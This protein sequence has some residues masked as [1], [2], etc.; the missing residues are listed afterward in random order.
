MV[1]QRSAVARWK[2]VHALAAGFALALGCMLAAPPSH[3]DTVVQG[4]LQL[5]WADP[6]RAL[7]GRAKAAPQLDV[8]LETAP[9][10]RVPLDAAQ[11]RRAAG[12]L[13]ALANR[14]VAVSYEASQSKAS[15]VASSPAIGAIV[16]TGRVAARATAV[17]ADSRVMAA[18]AVLG[19]TRWVTLMCKF[20]DIATE[21]KPREFFQAQ[22][23][24]SPGQLGHYWSE[25]SYGQVDLAG[26]SAHGWYTLPQ[27]R[28]A[29]LAVVNG[30]QKAQLSQLFADCAAAADAD[31]DFRGAQGVNL[32]F[33]GEL[34]GNAWGGGAC[35]TLDGAYTCTRV[36]W[37]PPWSFANLAP[38]AHEMGH[39]YGLPHSNNSDGDADTYDNPWDLMSDAW[40]NSTSDAT[41]GTLPKHINMYQRERLGWLPAARKRVIEADNSEA[42]EFVLDAGSLRDSSNAQLVILALPTQA[43]PYKTVIY[44][45]EARRRTGT[46]ESKLAGDAVIIHKLEDYGIAY[47][48]DTDTPAADVSNNEGS[49]LKVGERWNTPDERH[50]VEVVAATADGFHVRVGPRPRSM[51]SPAPVLVKPAT[52]TASSQPPVSTGTPSTSVAVKPTAATTGRCNALPAL[53]RHPALCALLER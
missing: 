37:S 50:W 21:Q 6:P 40:R 7:P 36:T 27:P 2:R 12:D 3:A 45:L 51:S 19:S 35:A 25:V 24:N 8:W 28:E 26:S 32:M 34:D 18:S 5:Q 49:M 15:R 29:Y 41:F 14:H 31:V 33:N 13:Y 20:A 53:L 44:T 30:K 22:Y 11:A 47:S 42:Q 16:P 23:G 48:I 1:N 4:I 43:D 9:G 38:L 10:Q 39:G 52:Q 17:G 46:Y